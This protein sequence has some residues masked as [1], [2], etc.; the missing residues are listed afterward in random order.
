[1]ENLKNVADFDKDRD[2]STSEGKQEMGNLKGRIKK[3]KKEIEKWDFDG[4]IID[5]PK[6]Q[7]GIEI[8]I[9][10]LFE[11]FQKTECYG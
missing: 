3:L 4:L 5:R 7:Q 6:H 2:N 11:E 9:P 1:M 10:Q 8:Q